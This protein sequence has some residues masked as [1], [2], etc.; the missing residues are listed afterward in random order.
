MLLQKFGVTNK[1]HYGFLWYFWSGQLN[2]K[3]DYDLVKRCDKITCPVYAFTT[4]NG[5]F[6]DLNF[7]VILLYNALQHLILQITKLVFVMTF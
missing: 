3:H 6:M 5:N 4:L 1:E 2:A 7:V